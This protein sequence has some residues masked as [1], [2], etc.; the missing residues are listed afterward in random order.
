MSNAARK[1]PITFH[2]ATLPQPVLLSDFDHN[3]PN[4]QVYAF[5]DK[6]AD[7]FNTAID[8]IAAANPHLTV[9]ERSEEATDYL[10]VII[11]KARNG[12]EPLRLEQRFYRTSD[13]SAGRERASFFYV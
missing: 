3:D 13:F 8:A 1:S 7:D 6:C 9:F 10:R 4:E 11:G 2:N 5:E 12:S